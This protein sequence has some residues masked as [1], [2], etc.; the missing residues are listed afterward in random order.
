MTWLDCALL[1]MAALGA[2]GVVAASRAA[3]AESR[4]ASRAVLRVVAVYVR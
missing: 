4:R 1:A 3:F 2:G